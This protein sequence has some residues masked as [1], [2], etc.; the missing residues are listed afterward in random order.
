MAP[1]LISI[2]QV[3]QH[4]PPQEMNRELCH[5]Q[6]ALWELLTTELIFLRKLKIMTDV[7]HLQLQPHLLPTWVLSIVRLLP[8]QK[9]RNGG[10][11]RGKIPS[12]DFRSA[13]AWEREDGGVGEGLEKGDQMLSP[14]PPCL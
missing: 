6:E 11:G 5:Q 1:T 14:C 4:C 9:D 8:E 2:P 12:R 10:R 13:L 7:S 3:N